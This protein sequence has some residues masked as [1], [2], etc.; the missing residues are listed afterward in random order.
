[1]SIKRL[2]FQA[3]DSKDSKS[4]EGGIICSELV[5]FRENVKRLENAI[6]IAKEWPSWL[7][8]LP[9][10]GFENIHVWI[11]T[12]ISEKIEESLCSQFMF[13]DIYGFADANY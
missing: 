13:H 3:S 11:S 1:L 4:G 5:A 6:A 7:F 9:G 10:M 2:P 8:V 12:L